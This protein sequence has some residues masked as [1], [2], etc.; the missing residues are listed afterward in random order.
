MCKQC[1]ADSSQKT[2]SKKGKQFIPEKVDTHNL[3]SQVIISDCNKCPPLSCPC[4][5]FCHKNG[6]NADCQN[7]IIFT[8]LAR[9]LKTQ[10]SCRRHPQPNEPSGHTSPLADNPHD[11][12]LSG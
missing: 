3:R 10:Y 7:Q 8:Q 2:A 4:Q 11:D 6:D 1:P 12:K 5:V 9:K